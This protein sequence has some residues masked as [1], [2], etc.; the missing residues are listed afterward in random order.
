MREAIV[1]IEVGNTSG[2][3]FFIDKRGYILTNEH[4][5]TTSQSVTVRFANGSS[6]I[7]QVISTDAA[8]DIALL[9][10]NLQTV[11]NPLR[12]ATSVEQGERVIALGHPLGARLG[13]DMTMTMGVVSAFRTYTSGSYIQT[14]ASINPGNSGGPLLNMKGEVVGMNTSSIDETTSGRPVEGIGF[15]IRH[16]VLQSRLPVLL[17]G[18]SAAT[19]TPIPATPRTTATPTPA[20]VATSGRIRHNPNNDTI[21]TYDPNIWMRDGTMSARFTNPDPGPEGWSYGFMFRNSQWGYLHAFVIKDRRVWCHYL[22]LGNL[23]TEKQACNHSIAIKTAVGGE[24]RIL[25]MFSGSSG[26]LWVN[27]EPMGDLNLSDLMDRGKVHVVGTFFDGDA[28]ANGST[29]FQD[30]SIESWD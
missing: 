28:T 4:V 3:G 29:I 17:A 21:D 14:D 22:R 2:S 8:R 30:L 27:L 25:L 16:D 9:K 10:V 15:A 23:A 6:T 1:R 20:P 12:F 13:T 24:N 18:T 19:P 26:S 5:V 7:A 11:I